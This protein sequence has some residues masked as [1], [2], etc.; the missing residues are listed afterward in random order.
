[1]SKNPTWTHGMFDYDFLEKEGM[2]YM[3]AN[4]VAEP[5]AGLRRISRAGS[6]REV[7][8]RGG[9]WPGEPRT[10]GGGNAGVEKEFGGVRERGGESEQSVLPCHEYA[11]VES[12][13]RVKERKGGEREGGGNAGVENGSMWRCVLRILY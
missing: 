7:V 12:E 1:M 13:Q 6:P 2:C 3:H 10:S 4:M 9:S 11:K 5:S 8:P